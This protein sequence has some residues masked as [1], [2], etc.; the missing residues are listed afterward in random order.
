MPQTRVVIRVVCAAKGC[1]L[2]PHLVDLDALSAAVCNQRRAWISGVPVNQQF[3]PTVS[4]SQNARLGP[5]LAVNV[6][7]VR[8]TLSGLQSQDKPGAPAEQRRRCFISRAEKGARKSWSGRGGKHPLASSTFQTAATDSGH[9]SGSGEKCE[10]S[11]FVPFSLAANCTGVILCGRAYRRSPRRTPRCMPCTGCRCRLR[12]F[13][14]GC[15]DRPCWEG[16]FGR[17]VA[18]EGGGCQGGAWVVGGG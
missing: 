10:R 1:T 17:H 7:H 18:G 12:T 15:E 14:G 3:F 6:E 11:L 8:Q 13:G 16:V 5:H 2:A 4:V 9:S